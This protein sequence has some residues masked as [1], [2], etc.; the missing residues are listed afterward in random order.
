VIGE[1]DRVVIRVTGRGTHDGAFQGIPPSGRRV[2]ATGIA[3][4]WAAYDAV[5]L[6]QQIGAIPVP[7]QTSR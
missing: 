1:G 2:T 6:L 4:A 7:G 3:K 5:G